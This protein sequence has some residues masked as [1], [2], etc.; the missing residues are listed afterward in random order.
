MEILNGI[1]IGQYTFDI[2]TVMEQIKWRCLAS[3]M[4]YVAFSVAP[5]A[6]TNAPNENLE[7]KLIELSKFLKENKI[8]FSFS[9]TH[10]GNFGFK[11]EAIIEMKK[12]AG[13]YFLGC[14]MPECGSKYGCSGTGYGL[15]E[16]KHKDLQDAKDG[17]IDHINNL[18]KTTKLPEELW[19]SISDF[20]LALYYGF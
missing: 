6:K 3:G 9:C 17:F 15:T 8:Y 7:E 20:S 11:T 5:A 10:G 2:D 12:I 1:R 14:L 18:L 13:E 4:N 19:D 16:R